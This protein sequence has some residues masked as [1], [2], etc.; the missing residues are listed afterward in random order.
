MAR[1]LPN[2]LSLRLLQL[3]LERK[4]RRVGAAAPG[5]TFGGSQKRIPGPLASWCLRAEKGSAS[6]PA[7]DP[8]GEGAGEFAR[9][10]LRGK[11]FNS[12]FN[13]QELIYYFAS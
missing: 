2:S 3:R 8:F 13:N 12:W 7:R 1:I 6:R 11:G 9:R 10:R 4:G 5:A